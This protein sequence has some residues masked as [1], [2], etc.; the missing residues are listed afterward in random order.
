MI[1]RGNLK[2]KKGL[3]TKPAWLLFVQVQQN[4]ILKRQYKTE[5][6]MDRKQVSANR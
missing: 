2:K 4:R 6:L 1:T 5:S 3:K